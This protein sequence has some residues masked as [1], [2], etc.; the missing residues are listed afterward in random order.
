Q[1]REPHC[2]RTTRTN[3]GTNCD[4]LQN[5]RRRDRQIA[6]RNGGSDFEGRFAAAR[7][8]RRKGARG[9]EPGGGIL[10]EQRGSANNPRSRIFA[11]EGLRQSARGYRRQPQDGAANATCALLQ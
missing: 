4:R 8:T 11:E 10:S 2:A 7:E 6:K 5:G 9:C 3:D 1:R